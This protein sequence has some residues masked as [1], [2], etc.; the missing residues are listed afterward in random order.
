MEKQINF[1][2]RLAVFTYMPLI[3]RHKEIY[4][5]FLVSVYEF[6][7]TKGHDDSFCSRGGLHLKLH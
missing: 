2:H 5:P 3:V 6:L 7:Q 1:G 4:A